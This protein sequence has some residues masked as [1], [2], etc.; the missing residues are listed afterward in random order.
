ME[1]LTL[2]PTHPAPAVE[3]SNAMY[4]WCQYGAHWYIVFIPA[5]QRGQNARNSAVTA[6]HCPRHKNEFKAASRAALRARIGKARRGVNVEADP[7]VWV[8]H[9]IFNTLRMVKPQPEVSAEGVSA[10]ERGWPMPEAEC[11][12]GRLSGDPCPQPSSTF[13]EYHDGERVVLPSRSLWPHN[14]PCGCFEAEAQAY[15]DNVERGV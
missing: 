5:G 15:L 13:V 4:R 14:Y 11:E 7:K 9:L 12:H 10:F 8:R 6:T 3:G 2:K 1:F